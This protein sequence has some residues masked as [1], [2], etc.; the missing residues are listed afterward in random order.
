[1]S[2]RAIKVVVYLAVIVLAITVDS[3]GG[4]WGWIVAAIMLA[5]TIPAFSCVAK[6]AEHRG[7]SDYR[8]LRRASA[9]RILSSAPEAPDVREVGR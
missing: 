1:M 5:G 4:T 9:R 8:R 7:V 6:A 3:I 2:L